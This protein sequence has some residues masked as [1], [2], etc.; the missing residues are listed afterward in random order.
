MLKHTV[1]KDDKS[2]NGEIT[3]APS[4]SISSRMIIIQAIRRSGLDQSKLDG[5]EDVNVIDPS[6]REGETDLTTG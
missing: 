5:S 1:L 4:K 2:L 3:L 6:V